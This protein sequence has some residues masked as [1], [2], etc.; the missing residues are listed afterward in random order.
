MPAITTN[1][2]KNGIT[3]Q[4]DNG[5]FQVV[6]FQHV[7]PG[8]GGAFVRTKLRNVRTGAVLEKHLQRRHPRRAGDRRS[9]GH[10]VP[11]PRRRRLRVH[12]HLDLRPA[13]RR[14]GQAR[15][16]RRLPRRAGGGPDR[17]ARRRDHRR[18]DPGV[19]RARRSASPSPACRAI[20]CPGRASRPSWRPARS[21]RCR[22]SSTSAT[23]CGS[24]R[25]PASTS[26]ACDDETESRAAGPSLR[27]PRAGALPALRG[28]P[29]GRAR[30][31]RARRSGRA[32]RRADHA[33]RHRRRR[34]P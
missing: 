30:R 14:P 6:E 16:R 24:T 18:R 1:D 13:A 12:E 7:K 31:R 29:E 32:R 17:P 25:G 11:V 15:R 34:R 4:L 23:G 22:C 20:A 3:L 10:A 28:R 19:G 9:P 21:C 27:R 8:K 26:L 2:L 5:L 33:A